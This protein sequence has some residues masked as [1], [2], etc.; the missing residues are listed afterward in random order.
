MR[1]ISKSGA[2]TVGAK[3]EMKLQPQQEDIFLPGLI[4]KRK[5][6]KSKFCF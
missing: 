1:H 5:E 4:P 6:K 3:P 2:R